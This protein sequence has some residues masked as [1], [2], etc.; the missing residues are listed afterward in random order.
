METIAAAPAA[1]DAFG[2]LHRIDGRP[3][4]ELDVEVVEG[5]A[6]DVSTVKASERLEARRAGI[7]DADVV[8]IGGDGKAR[9]A[10]TVASGL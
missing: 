2:G 6:F 3:A 8:E 4:S 5:D 9:H 10:G 7:F 1:D